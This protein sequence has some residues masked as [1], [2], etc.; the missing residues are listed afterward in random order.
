[1][2][3]GDIARGLG[4]PDTTNIHVLGEKEEEKKTLA[5]SLRQKIGIRNQ[6]YWCFLSVNHT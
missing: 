3:G 5:A 2:R 4:E 6:R 1:M